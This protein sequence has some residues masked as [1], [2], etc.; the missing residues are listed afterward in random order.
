[1]E[2]EPLCVKEWSKKGEERDNE[3]EEEDQRVVRKLKIMVW[4][5]IGGL[6]K[7]KSQE[8]ER[9]RHKCHVQKQGTV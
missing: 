6:N 7:N 9:N 8:G 2:D 5:R 3:G 4:V 1:M